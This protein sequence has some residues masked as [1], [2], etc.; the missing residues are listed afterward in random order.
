M[1]GGLLDADVVVPVVA[2]AVG[3]GVEDD[4]LLS[5]ALSECIISGALHNESTTNRYLTF[6]AE[7]YV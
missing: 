6:Y 3:D 2:D 4:I 1:R 5:T 7:N